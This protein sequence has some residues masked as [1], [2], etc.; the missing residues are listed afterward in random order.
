MAPGRRAPRRYSPSGADPGEGTGEQS[1]AQRLAL[2]LD[3][4]AGAAGS[5]LACQARPGNDHGQLGAEAG[6]VFQQRIG[7]AEL[8]GRTTGKGIAAHGCQK[9]PCRW[10]GRQGNQ[11]CNQAWGGVLNGAAM[12]L[13]RRRLQP[14]AAPMPSR[15]RG[16]GTAAEGGFPRT[17]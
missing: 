17:T 12:R 14:K 5:G 2:S 3:V 15:G 1:G 16:P 7:G 10:Q 9:K 8:N 13:R 11:T 6:A 4:C